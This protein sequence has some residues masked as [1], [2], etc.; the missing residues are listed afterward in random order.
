MN[1][2]QKPQRAFLTVTL[3]TVLAVTMV[4]MVYAVLLTTYTGT[5]VTVTE[6]GGSLQYST[7][8]SAWSDTIGPINNGTTWYTKLVITSAASQDVTI[9]WTLEKY[10]TIWTNTTNT[11]KTY[12]TMQAGSIYT[13]SDGTGPSSNYNWGQFT[14]AP[15]TAG[16][17]RVV[18]DIYSP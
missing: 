16:D 8:N 3:I 11:F 13:T 14:S 4:F 10:T 17:Y 18:A 7:D 6:S 1:V 9:I 12:M 2:T 15:G 5:T